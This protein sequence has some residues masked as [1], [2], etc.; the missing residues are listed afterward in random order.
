MLHT[1]KLDYP[2]P[3]NTNNI[4][5]YIYM[6]WRMQIVAMT[7]TRLWLFSISSIVIFHVSQFPE[8]HQHLYMLNP[9]TVSRPLPHSRICW[10]CSNGYNWNQMFTRVFGL[11][12]YDYVFGWLPDQDFPRIVWIDT[13]S[14]P[15]C[16]HFNISRNC[17][18][19]FQQKQSNLFRAVR[20]LWSTK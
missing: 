6:F 7:I 2:L 18:L 17:L 8:I 4:Y 5:I 15:P 16:I 9:Y 3:L 19:G 1:C 13:T 14:D 20:G 11:E 10:K 12:A